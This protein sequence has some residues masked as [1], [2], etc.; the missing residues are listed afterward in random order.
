MTGRRT[1]DEVKSRLEDVGRLLRERH[2]G[3]EPDANFAARVVARLPRD[4]AWT[5]ARAATRIVPVSLVFAVALMIAVVATVRSTS[6]ITA[7]TPLSATVQTEDDPL[8]WL[9]EGREESR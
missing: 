2:A 4:T 9:L 5:L 7:S 8:E 3:I 1:R 6:R